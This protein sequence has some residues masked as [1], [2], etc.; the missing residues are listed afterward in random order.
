MKI[1]THQMPHILQVL[2]HHEWTWGI[3]A[4][5]MLVVPN[6]CT[7]WKSAN[8]RVLMVIVPFLI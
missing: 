3:V 1:M 7:T 2:S 5:V 4:I 6:K 8:P